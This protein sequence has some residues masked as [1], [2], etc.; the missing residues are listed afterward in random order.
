MSWACQRRASAA[1]FA[2]R[3]SP[4]GLASRKTVIVFGSTDIPSTLCVAARARRRRQSNASCGKLRPKYASRVVNILQGGAERSV[5]L[6]THDRGLR[7][8]REMKACAAAL[9]E[10]DWPG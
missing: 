6:Q 5:A 7:V 2:A 1:A 10:K 9:V 4:E 3:R 8:H